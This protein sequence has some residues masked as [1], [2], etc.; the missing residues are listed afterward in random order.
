MHGT[1]N[2][3][4]R[5]KSTIPAHVP[6][7]LRVAASQPNGQPQ[8]GAQTKATA[9][10]V[11][12]ILASSQP[13]AAAWH[14][15]VH[16]SPITSRPRRPLTGANE[17]PTA[18]GRT[19]K[20]SLK[21]PHNLTTSAGAQRRLCAHNC[22][23]AQ[24]PSASADIDRSRGRPKSERNPRTSTRNHGRAKERRGARCHWLEARRCN[25]GEERRNQ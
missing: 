8:T 16:G 18:E 15:R 17:D 2:N 4:S 7:H 21:Q 5:P 14:R 10:Q 25:A 3:H 12:A 23:G 13:N 6:P 22:N 19:Q 11:A 20:R 9:H 24:T 1:S